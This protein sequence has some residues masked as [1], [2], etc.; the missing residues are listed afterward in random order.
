MCQQ[1]EYFLLILTHMLHQYSDSELFAN[2]NCL[3][4]PY[5][6]LVRMFVCLFAVHT[7]HI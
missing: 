6:G 4:S 1:S 7:Q 2:D 3:V 5:D